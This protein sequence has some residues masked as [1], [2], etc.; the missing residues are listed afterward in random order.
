MRTGRRR[1]VDF[2]ARGVLGI[3]C[4]F[5]LLSCGEQSQTVPTAPAAPTASLAPWVPD[6][7]PQSLR[8]LSQDEIAANRKKTLDFLAEEAGL[9]PA[10]TVEIVRWIRAIDFAEVQ[11]G[12]MKEE[13]W[14]VTTDNGTIVMDRLPDSQIQAYKASKYVCE[15]KFPVDAREVVQ[16]S[17]SQWET[18][19]DYKTQWVSK[20]L[21]LQGYRVPTPP[22]RDVW[23][24]AGDKA[25]AWDVYSLVPQDDWFKAQLACPA[26][27]DFKYLWS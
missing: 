11:G 23:V 2:V 27:P 12:C 24:A 14:P 26:F 7:P 16:L 6:H 10:P 21:A 15:A 22:T 19:Y 4:A 8:H 3:T 9:D 18:M 13:G 17:V 5:L 25:G 20:C 1:F